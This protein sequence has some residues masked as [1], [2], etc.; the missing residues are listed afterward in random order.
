MA[1]PQAGVELLPGRLK[2]LPLEA[3][4]FSTCSLWAT[5]T[6]SSSGKL[7]YGPQAPEPEKSSDHSSWAGRTSTTWD[8]CP[9]VGV[10]G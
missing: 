1:T 9:S 7:S 5:S 4:H 10:W 8:A 6:M 2:S 3:E